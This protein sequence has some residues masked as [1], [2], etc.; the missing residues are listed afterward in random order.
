M[1][2]TKHKSYYTLLATILDQT[3]PTT[4]GKIKTDNIKYFYTNDVYKLNSFL[5]YDRKG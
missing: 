3:I 4:Y 5:N 2:K 1:K